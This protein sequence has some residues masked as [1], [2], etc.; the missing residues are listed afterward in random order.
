[1]SYLSKRG[2]GRVV[3]RIG[4]PHELR[5]WL[6]WLCGVDR[7]KDLAARS[8]ATAGLLIG[9]RDVIAAV[10]LCRDVVAGD[11]NK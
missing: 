9:I 4:E 8:L 6:S 5:V 7:L 11:R 1:M 3:R 2:F 10:G